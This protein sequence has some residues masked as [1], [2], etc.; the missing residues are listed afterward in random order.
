MAA[1]QF[2]VF[3]ILILLRLRRDGNVDTSKHL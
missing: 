2:V 3:A 1:G